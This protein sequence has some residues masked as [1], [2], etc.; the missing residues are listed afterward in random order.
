M[1]RVELP[2]APR[3][4]ER[5][6]VPSV[7]PM[8]RLLLWVRLA[9]VRSAE[10]TPVPPRPKPEWPC[11]RHGHCPLASRRKRIAHVHQKRFGLPSAQ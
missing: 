1:R 10:F 11:P 2:I 4:D 8:A 5:I 9:M 6:I 3:F 7:P